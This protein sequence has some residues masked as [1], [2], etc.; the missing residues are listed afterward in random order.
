MGGEWGGVGEVVDFELPGASARAMERGN[1]I[2]TEAIPCG[3]LLGLVGAHCTSLYRAEDIAVGFL[4]PFWKTIVV[5]ALLNAG[6][7]DSEITKIV[8]RPISWLHRRYTWLS[9]Y[10][11]NR[12]FFF[13]FKASS[14][15]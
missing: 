5:Q 9:F 12:P 8:N 11:L 1:A 2:D 13:L 6:F 7:P 3:G 15:K 14:Y 4:T 10:S